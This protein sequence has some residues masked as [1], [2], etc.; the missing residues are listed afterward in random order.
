VVEGVRERLAEIQPTLPKGVT[1]KVFYDRG[2]LVDRAIH[3]VSKALLEAILLVVI[4]LILFLKMYTTSYE[5]D[6]DKYSL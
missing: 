6:E 3:G 2:S 5:N 4:L 1:T